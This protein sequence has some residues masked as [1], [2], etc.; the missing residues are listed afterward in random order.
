MYSTI[1]ALKKKNL[2]ISDSGILF[3]LW[4]LQCPEDIFWKTFNY[5]FNFTLMVQSDSN[6]LFL[7]ESIQV[8]YI[9][10]EICSF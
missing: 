9:Y 3:Q 2:Y 6:F 7:I 4:F 10:L 1:Y 5:L 8:N